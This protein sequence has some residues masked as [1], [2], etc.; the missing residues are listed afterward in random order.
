M[1]DTSQK[2]EKAL[3]ALGCMKEGNEGTKCFVFRVMCLEKEILI[4]VSN[5]ILLPGNLDVTDHVFVSV[6][7]G[8]VVEKTVPDAQEYF[9]SQHNLLDGNIKT[10]R[11]QAMS[12]EDQMYAIKKVCSCLSILNRRW[13]L[14]KFNN[15]SNKL[16]NKRHKVM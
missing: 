14:K 1:K 6:G 10:M 3:E 15:N 9:S 2:A 11:S 13:R 12:I 16:Y 8:Y 5:N 7:A 4:P